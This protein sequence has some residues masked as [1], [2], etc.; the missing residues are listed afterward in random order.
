[1]KADLVVMNNITTSF[2]GSDNEGYH[3]QLSPTTAIT[4][5]EVGFKLVVMNFL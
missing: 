3:Q 4:G 5:S 2:D 1:L